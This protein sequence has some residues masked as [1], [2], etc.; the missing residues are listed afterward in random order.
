MSYFLSRIPLELGVI[1]ELTGDE[2][3]HILLSRRIEVGEIIEIQ[4]PNN[5]RFEAEVIDIDRKSLSIQAISEI[6]TP[7]ES[8]LRITV[9]QALIKE[10]PLDTII[11]KI[12]EL[13]VYALTLFYSENSVERYK[14]MGKKLGRWRKIS[15]E[16][17]KQS[18]RVRPV[19]IEFVSDQITLLTRLDE[20][21]KIFILEPL[22]GSSFLKF[23]EKN[24]DLSNIG[25]LVGPEGGFTA[26]EVEQF[27]NLRNAAPIYLGPRILRADTAAISASAII[28][29]LWGD[30]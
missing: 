27:S 12:T 26:I 15:E 19:H 6:K 22:S 8:P 16:A 14:D 11:Q 29:S 5:K 30:M 10:Q 21:E 25:I 3:R 4:D 13:G 18:G 7:E 28:Q 9:F 20:P 17:A 24:K 1:V 23:R 2:A